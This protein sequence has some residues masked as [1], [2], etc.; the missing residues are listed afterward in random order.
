MGFSSIR[1]ALLREPTPQ[2][3]AAERVRLMLAD[4]ETVVSAERRGGRLG[5]GAAV[6]VALMAVVAL[7]PGKTAPVIFVPFGIAALL[8]VF[9]SW[10]SRRRSEQAQ[11]RLRKALL[12]S[13]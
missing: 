7:G 13:E 11:A 10:A 8:A 1:R 6:I 3:Q 5:F 4:L 9:W 2:K 12:G